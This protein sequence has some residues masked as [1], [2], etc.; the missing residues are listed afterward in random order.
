V[1]KGA[2]VAASKRSSPPDEFAAGRGVEAVNIK[3]SIAESDTKGKGGRR[4]E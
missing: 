3:N 4:K 1:V 2:Y